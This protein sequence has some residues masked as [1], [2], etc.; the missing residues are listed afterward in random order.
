MKMQKG[1]PAGPVPLLA[2]RHYF[3]NLPT[4]IMPYNLAE[5]HQNARQRAHLGHAEQRERR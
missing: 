1:G 5:T 3:D 2:R 4:V